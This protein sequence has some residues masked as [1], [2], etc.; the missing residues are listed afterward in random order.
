MKTLR[1]TYKSGLEKLTILNELIFILNG[2]SS[3]HSRMSN[4]R[5]FKKWNKLYEHDSFEL[6]EHVLNQVYNEI[7]KYKVDKG[8]LS[9]RVYNLTWD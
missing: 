2:H 1:T 8:E 5:I 6:M 7:R 4:N 9:V 3:N